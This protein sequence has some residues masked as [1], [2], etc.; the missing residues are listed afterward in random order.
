MLYLGPNTKS[1]TETLHSGPVHMHSRILCI[2]KLQ[3]Q[4]ILQKIHVI[5]SVIVFY[6][7]VIVPAP[8]VISVNHD[9]NDDYVLKAKSGTL[10]ALYNKKAK[11]HQAKANLFWFS[12]SST[13]PTGNVKLIVL[14]SFFK[15]SLCFE[16]HRF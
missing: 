6:F 1:F 12:Y 15:K 13:F 14:I 16:T 5:N 8:N 3:I 10:S 11:L 7:V 2:K 4:N 9:N